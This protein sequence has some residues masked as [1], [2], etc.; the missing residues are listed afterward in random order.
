V[1]GHAPLGFREGFGVDA[2][3]DTLGDPEAHARVCLH[4][5]VLNAE[6]LMVS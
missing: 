1:F 5:S 6:A 2:A 3:F 4:V